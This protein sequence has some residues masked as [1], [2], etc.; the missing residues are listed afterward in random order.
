MLKLNNL[1]F[2]S[3]TLVNLSNYRKRESLT[4]LTFLCFFSFMKKESRRIQISLRFTANHSIRQICFTRL[5]I[6]YITI[7]RRRILPSHFMLSNLRIPLSI[8]HSLSSVHQGIKDASRGSGRFWPRSE[9]SGWL[10]RRKFGICVPSRWSPNERGL[11]TQILDHS[12]CTRQE[13]RDSRHSLKNY[14]S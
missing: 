2:L 7:K 1:P 3:H 4:T 6:I 14:G 5:K 9:V 8:D 13:S 10:R 11:P 12:A